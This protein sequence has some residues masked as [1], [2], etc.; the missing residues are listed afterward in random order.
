VL[1]D[2]DNVMSA[3]DFITMLLGAKVLIWLIKEGERGLVALVTPFA[4]EYK[5]A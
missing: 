4:S 5:K 3:C 1:G 2:F